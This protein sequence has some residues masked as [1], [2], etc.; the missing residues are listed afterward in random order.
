MSAVTHN[1][2]RV[3]TATSPSAIPAELIDVKAVAAI[4]GC[5]AR[6]VQT[7]A[8]GG[9]M[10]KPVKLRGLTRWRRT[11]VNQWIEKGCCPID[12]KGGA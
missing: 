9:W 4:L 6:H 11:D 12:P 5:S 1:C 8:Q 2:E 7:M 3:F 10:P